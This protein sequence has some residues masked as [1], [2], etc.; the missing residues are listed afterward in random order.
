M[1]ITKLQI[2]DLS[3]TFNLINI[4]TNKKRLHLPTLYL[5]NTLWLVAGWVGSLVQVFWKE[6]WEK[7]ENERLLTWNEEPPAYCIDQR[8]MIRNQVGSFERQNHPRALQ[9]TWVSVITGIS[10]PFFCLLSGSL[11]CGLTLVWMTLIVYVPL[12]IFNIFW[13]K[14]YS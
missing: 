1:K 8:K 7:S 2:K 3:V 13:T 6:G 5:L 9:T 14:T 4:M 10:F 11:G 12:I